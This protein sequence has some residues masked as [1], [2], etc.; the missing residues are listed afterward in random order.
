MYIQFKDFLIFNNVEMYFQFDL[1]LKSQ[2][3]AE[4]VS[5]FFFFFL[6]TNRIHVFIHTFFT[7]GSGLV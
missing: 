5:V 3:N 7:P 1:F 6:K 2:E 4:A